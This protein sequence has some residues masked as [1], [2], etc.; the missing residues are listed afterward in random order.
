MFTEQKCHSE[1][2]DG[3]CVSERKDMKRRCGGSVGG[4]RRGDPEL[5]DSL[6]FQRPKGGPDGAGPQLRPHSQAVLK[7]SKGTQALPPL[8]ELT[9]YNSPQAQLESVEFLQHGAKML[10]S[11]VLAVC[12][13]HWEPSCA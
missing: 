4:E 2:L 5:E 3:V 7:P 10:R 6:G 9:A 12:T 13:K 11:R 8:C 1:V